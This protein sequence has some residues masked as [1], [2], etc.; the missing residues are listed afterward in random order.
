M[1]YCFV[2]YLSLRSSQEVSLWAYQK[3]HE[4]QSKISSIIIFAE[5]IHF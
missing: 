5:N 3:D 2:N 4:G 1:Q